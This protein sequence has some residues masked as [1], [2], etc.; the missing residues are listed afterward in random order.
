[1]SQRGVWN[2]LENEYRA[3]QEAISGYA[4]DAYLNYRLNDPFLRSLYRNRYAV[5]RKSGGKITTKRQNRYKNEPSE[6]I[7]IEQNKSTHKLVAKLNDN[8][9]KTFLKTL[10]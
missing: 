10:K 9:I 1:M 3:N 7:W 6:D 4:G 8:I 5:A 2:Q